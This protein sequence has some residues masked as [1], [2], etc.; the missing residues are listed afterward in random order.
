[1]TGGLV[2]WP[3]AWAT[4]RERGLAPFTLLCLA[5]IFL[6]GWIRNTADA[7]GAEAFS[8]VSSI[9][10]FLLVLS[11]G[12]G[13]LSDEV[14]SG[15]AQLVL[16]RPIT[17]AQ[18]VAGRL[19]GAVLVLC[20]GGFLGWATNLLA[21]VAFRGGAGE[22]PARLLVLPL[23]L[24]PALGWLATATALSAFIRG[25]SNSGILLG[26]R[27]AWLATRY[28]APVAFP[29]LG[30]TPM[31][32]AMDPY[33]GPQKLFDIVDQVRSGGPV[34]VSPALWDVFWFFAAW[35]AAVWLFNRRELAR[36]RS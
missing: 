21:A 34:V 10:F 1:V 16:L 19:V 12:G 9:W 31:L 18:W 24:L 36:R 5:A 4:A 15:H 20:L 30:L 32:E 22:I 11:L 35:T 25:W 26:A 23:G 7:F 33:V 28:G 8:N 6:L 17:R 13:L 27:A 29:Q 2:S 3:I 14:D